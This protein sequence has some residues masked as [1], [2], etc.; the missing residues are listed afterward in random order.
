MA[1]PSQQ[2]NPESVVHNF[3][4]RPAVPVPIKCGIYGPQGSGMSTSAALMAAAISA[5]FYDRAPVF[6][7]DPEAAWQLSETAHLRRRRH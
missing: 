1:T 2:R 4:K 3:P 7:V 5:Q 6:V